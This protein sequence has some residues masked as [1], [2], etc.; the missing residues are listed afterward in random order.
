VI[1]TSR[2][3]VLGVRVSIV[4]CDCAV[5]SIIESAKNRQTLGV[6]A[7]A[8]HGVMSAVHDSEYL[9]RVNHLELVTPDGQPVRWFLNVKYKA[10]L[11]DRVYGP[12]LTLR[13]LERAEAEGIPVYFYG[14]TP[15]TVAALARSMTK[16]FPALRIAGAEASKFRRL[17]PREK[18]ELVNRIHESGARILFVGLGCPRQEVFVYE[19]KD[20]LKMPLLAVGAAFDYHSGNLKEPPA[21]LQRYGLQWLHRLLEEPRRLFYRYAVHNAEFLM[22][23]AFQ[24]LGV[25]NPGKRGQGTP[26]QGE[27]LFG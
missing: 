7:L 24:L 18:V 23:G 6:T 19:F 16:R 17:E 20:D 3:S 11:K 2:Q 21:I 22:L 4:T 15:Q 27:S 12:T 8:V 10:R 13:V 25:W 14:S 1:A 26:P 5:D 9:Y